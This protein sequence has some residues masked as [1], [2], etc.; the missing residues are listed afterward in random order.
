MRLIIVRKFWIIRICLLMI[1]VTVLIA[2]FKY[3][4]YIETTNIPT[5]DKFIVI[6]PG[7][8][9]FD[10]G[11]LGNRG[12]NEKEIN[13]AISLYLCEYLEKNG[14]VVIMTREEDVDLY[15]DDGS[16]RKMKTIDLTN[17]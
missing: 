17:R 10:P 2:L 6:D 11:K 7:H 1:S 5:T 12:K 4:K 3:Y 9:G 8:G 14:Y 13:L 15:I 16:N